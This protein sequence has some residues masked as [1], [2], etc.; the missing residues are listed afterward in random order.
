MY[1]SWPTTLSGGHWG[2]SIKLIYFFKSLL[3]YSEAWFRQNTFIVM[4][5]TK[6]GYGLPNC[7]F[8][9]L[10]EGV[11]VLGRGHISHLV[12]MHYFCKKSLLFCSNIYVTV[13]ACGP[14]VLNSCS[15]L[16]SQ[17]NWTNQCCLTF[18]SLKI[19]V[20]RSFVKN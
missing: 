17:N 7:E 2:K 16:Y 20:P 15:Q 3:H 12:K 10:G 9:D 11:L 8:H 19:G 5:R 4:G 13:K 1:I 6:D 14:L 18:L